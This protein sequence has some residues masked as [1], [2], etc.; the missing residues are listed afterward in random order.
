MPSYKDNVRVAIS[1]TPGTSG[2]LTVGAA[3]DATYAAFAAGDN[4]LTFHVTAVEPGVGT[5]T[6]ESVYTHAG[7]SLSRGNRLSSTSGARIN[8]TSAAVVTVVATADAMTKLDLQLDR[9]TTTV[10]SNGATQQTFS[11][12]AGDY[13]ITVF[14]TVAQN[15]KS[16]WSSGTNR[17]TPLRA[18]TYLV[19]FQTQII[20]N[21]QNV[22]KIYKNGSALLLAGNYGTVGY[23]LSQGSVLVTMNGTTDYLEPY[24]YVGTNSTLYLSNGAFQAIYLGS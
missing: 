7:T 6:F 18:G 22:A 8:L 19:F 13:K 10:T 12:G 14:S 21:V 20:E 11:S 15:P 16:W 24:V 2:A 3:V 4:G 5:E 23:S 1:N 9:A 17:F